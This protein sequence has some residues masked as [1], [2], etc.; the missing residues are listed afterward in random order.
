MDMVLTFGGHDVDILTL[1][2]S[3]RHDINP[4]FN[5]VGLHGHDVYMMFVFMN[6]ML[7]VINMMLVFIDMMLSMSTGYCHGRRSTPV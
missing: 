6:M 2:T 3:C 5:E 7:I 4:C 1:R